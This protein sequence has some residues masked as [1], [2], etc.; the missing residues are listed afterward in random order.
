M[1]DSEALDRI[2]SLMDGV[3]WDADTLS[4]IA[5]IVRRTLNYDG[6]PRLI[7]DPDEVQL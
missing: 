6:S 5:D 7:R 1:T 4:E 2:A 3:E